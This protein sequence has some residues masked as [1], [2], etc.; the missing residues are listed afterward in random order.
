MT[1]SIITGMSKIYYDNIGKS[2][3]ESWLK[4]WPKSFELLIY[5]ED[6][7]PNHKPDREPRRQLP[8]SDQSHKYPLN[9][10]L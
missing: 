7:M 4:F 6:D 8:F 10:L 5:S 9:K 1:Y 2:M 3:L